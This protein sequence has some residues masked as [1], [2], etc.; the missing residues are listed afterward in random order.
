MFKESFK[1]TKITFGSKSILNEAMVVFEKVFYYPHISSQI[2]DK[3][4]IISN[5][6][7]DFY[8]VAKK[9]T[10][11]DVVSVSRKVWTKAIFE[12]KYIVMYIQSSGYF[13]KFDPQN[14]KE[15]KENMRGDTYMINFSVREGKNLIKIKAVR[16]RIDLAI[17]KNRILKIREEEKEKEFAKQVLS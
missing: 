15:F 4:G 16:E 6:I 13:Y 1:N 12:K 2:K 17:L 7:S 3:Y 5:E 10:Y 8:L 11:G 9:E 14:I